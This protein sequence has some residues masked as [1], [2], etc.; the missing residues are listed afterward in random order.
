M[1]ILVP[2]DFSK[3]SKIATH[4]ACGMA[5]KLKADV[6]LVN[7]IYIDTNSKISVAFKA[8]KL[9]DVVSRNTREDGLQLIKELQSEYKKLNFSFE[10]IKGYPLEDRIENFATNNGIDLIVMGTKGASGIKKILMGSNAAAVIGKSSV[11][12]ITVPEHARFQPLKKIVYASDLQALEKQIKT[13]ISLLNILNVGL[14]ILH[15]EPLDSK[16]KSD[17]KRIENKIIKKYNYSKLSIK[18]SFNDD[19]EEAIGEYI[20][21]VKADM[22]VMFTHQLT[23]FEKLF[24]ESYTRRMAFQTWIPLLTIK[25]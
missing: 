2:T 6:I 22:L 8:K 11:P 20:D 7:V 4:Y 12:V 23:F 13:L 1:K 15:V 17:I 19:I 14:Y 10:I 21:D 16:K 3:F 18:V 9:E 24:N 25:K 5:K